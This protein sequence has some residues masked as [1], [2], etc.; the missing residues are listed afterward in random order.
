MIS[1]ARLRK[2]EKRFRMTKRV[3]S[4]QHTANHLLSRPI[5]A[6]MGRETLDL[7]FLAGDKVFRMVIWGSLR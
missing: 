1:V 6:I 2:S 4:V 3:G 7:S 5:K